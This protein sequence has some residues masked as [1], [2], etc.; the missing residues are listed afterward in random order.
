MSSGWAQV[1]LVGL[2]VENLLQS[3]EDFGSRSNPPGPAPSDHPLDWSS[4]STTEPTPSCQPPLKSSLAQ[5]FVYKAQRGI[6]IRDCLKSL[7][8]YAN[9]SNEGPVFHLVIPL[10]PSHT[11]EFSTVEEVFG[12]TDR[13]L[14]GS[15]RTRA[16][17]SLEIIHFLGS[18][19][20]WEG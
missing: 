18:L 1:Q 16:Y 6:W 17:R 15:Q 20:R 14:E 13:V 10:R 19:W 4:F 3:L 2:T 7:P 12:S 11:F 5:T 9:G 8:S